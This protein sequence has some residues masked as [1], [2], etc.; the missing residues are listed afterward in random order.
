MAEQILVDLEPVLGSKPGTTSEEEELVMGILD[1]FKEQRRIVA[2]EARVHAVL[3]VLRVRG[4]ALSGDGDI[5]VVG[6]PPWSEHR[7]GAGVFGA[8]SP[9]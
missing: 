8:G 6:H 5:A 7:A 3:T 9:G 4:I 2:T 1:T